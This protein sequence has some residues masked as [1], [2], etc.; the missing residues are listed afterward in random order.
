[1]CIAGTGHSEQFIFGD[2]DG[3]TRTNVTFQNKCSVTLTMHNALIWSIATCP[4]H[5]IAA[6]SASNGTVMVKLYANE[7]YILKPKHKV[8]SS[9]LKTH[10]TTHFKKLKSCTAKGIRVYSLQTD[11]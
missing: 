1:M 8:S 9:T 3:T 6:T 7:E 2:T 5:G 10:N 11:L 4:Y